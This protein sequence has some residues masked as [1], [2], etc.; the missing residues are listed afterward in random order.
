ME[1]L[2]IVNAI[3]FLVSGVV[4]LKDNTTTVDVVICVWLFIISFMNIIAA[5]SAMG[6][7]VKAAQ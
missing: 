1:Y 2:S 4:V 5:L 6:Y 7:I 3:I